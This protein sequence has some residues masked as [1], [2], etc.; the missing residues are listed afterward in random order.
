MDSQTERFVMRMSPKLLKAL[1]EWRRR[2]ADIPNRSETARRL[3]HMGLTF[4][5][6][7]EEMLSIIEAYHEASKALPNMPAELTALSPRFRRLA[8][9][10][11]ETVRAVEDRDEMDTSA[12]EAAQPP[13][14]PN[15]PRQTTPKRPS[16]KG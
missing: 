2:Q 13:S 1:D 10:L 11:M 6:V 8:D 15:R 14:D 12:D 3:L 7:I 9:R 5:D 4:D 16:K